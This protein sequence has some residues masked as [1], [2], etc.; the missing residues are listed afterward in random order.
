MIQTGE[1]AE[2]SELRVSSGEDSRPHDIAA[3]ATS[4]HEVKLLVI[5]TG[6]GEAKIFTQ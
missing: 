5:P 3:E 1:I 4:A 6:R 2:T